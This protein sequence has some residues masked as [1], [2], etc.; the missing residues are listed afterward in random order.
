MNP[1]EDHT[2]IHSMPAKAY[3]QYQ[4][5]FPNSLKERMPA[6]T[7]IILTLSAIIF[8]GLFAI[9]PTIGTIIELRRELEDAKLVNKKLEEKIANLEAL[10][11]QYAAIQDDLQFLT[12]AIPMDAQVA[13]LLGK[14]QAVVKE[15]GVTLNS[16]KIDETPLLNPYLNGTTSNRTAL[17]IDVSGSYDTVSS[18]IGKLIRIDRLILVDDIS[19]SRDTENRELIKLRTKVGA[20]FAK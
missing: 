4:R 9:N 16:M 13:N 3:L 6:Y 18:F 19:I 11:S 2:A 17:S 8:F 12:F 10:R 20:Y 14:T 5:L 15:S 7:T 1:I